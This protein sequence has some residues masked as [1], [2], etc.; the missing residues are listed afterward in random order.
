MMDK[1]KRFLAEEQGQDMA[2]YS[3]LLLLIGTVVLIYLTGM[4]TNLVAL[5]QQ[6]GEKVG[7]VKRSIS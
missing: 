3:L 6:I 2:E 1:M 7:L 5:L 4:G